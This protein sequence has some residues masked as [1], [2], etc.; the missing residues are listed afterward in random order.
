MKYDLVISIV[1]FNSSLDKIAL[2]LKQLSII[3]EF[4]IKTIIIDN[5]SRPDYFNKLINMHTDVISAGD[6]IGYGKAHN[7]LEKISPPSKYFLVLNPDINIEKNTIENLY[8][9]LNLN[10]D[11]GLVSPILKL[12]DEIFFDYRRENFTISN[13]IKRRL[14]KTK[15]YLSRDEINHIFNEKSFSEVQYIS[16]SFMF[17]KREVFNQINGFDKKFFMYFEDVDICDRIRK[18]SKISILKNS[19]AYH[20][21]QR[22][23]YKRIKFLIIHFLSYLKYK[24]T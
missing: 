19:E 12:S 11:Y 8:N 23:S 17:F 13:L 18:I 15:D 4:N 10:K 5:C 14:A 3:Q 2:L 20:Q 1:T 22:D 16:G 6:N 24:L 7:L 21:R 9:F